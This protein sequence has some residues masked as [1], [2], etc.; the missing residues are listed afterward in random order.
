MELGFISLLQITELR[1][2][3]GHLARDLTAVKPHR[4]LLVQKKY[5]ELAKRG[6][7]ER[8][9][10]SASRCLTH[11]HHE[12]KDMWDHGLG[13]GVGG[14]NSGLATS[15]IFPVPC[16]HLKGKTDQGIPQKSPR[17][18]CL[19]TSR[20]ALLQGYLQAAHTRPMLCGECEE[21]VLCFP[22]LCFNLSNQRPQLLL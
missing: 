17:G 12:F 19:Q 9:Y 10:K 22:P 4:Y 15:R 8:R 5:R 7:E 14:K 11:L 16:H 21:L 3:P 18:P 2:E 1:T 13:A 20:N 6:A